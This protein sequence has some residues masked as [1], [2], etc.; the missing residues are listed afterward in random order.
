MMWSRRGGAH[1]AILPTKTSLC[2]GWFAGVSLIFSMLVPKF[3]YQFRV[4]AVSCYF[5]RGYFIDGKSFI[6]HTVP[7]R[8]D[9]SFG[10]RLLLYDPF[11]S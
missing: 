4:I 9:L 8:T 6:D 11:T 5:H 7:S 10:K 3:P 1:H 2:H